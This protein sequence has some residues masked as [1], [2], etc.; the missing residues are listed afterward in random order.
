MNIH[1]IRNDPA[2][3]NI[4]PVDRKAGIWQSG[5]WQ[6]TEQ[7]VQWLI[8]GRVYFHHFQTAPSYFGGVILEIKMV[9]E[10]SGRALIIFRYEE[11]CRNSRTPKQGW[12]QELKY[13]D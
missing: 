6:M 9:P 8:G 10:H 11:A 2:L 1:V 3:P 5:Y 13:E 7:R 12:A 4:E